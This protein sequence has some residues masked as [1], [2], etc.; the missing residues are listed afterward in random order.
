MC[1]DTASLINVSC[2]AVRAVSQSMQQPSDQAARDPRGPASRQVPASAQV[3]MMM[4]MTTSRQELAKKIG[5][6]PVASRRGG[7]C[8][9]A[10]GGVHNDGHGRRCAKRR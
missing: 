5:G 1:H 10:G 9:A 8:D 4:M 7:G 3:A 6:R 2:A